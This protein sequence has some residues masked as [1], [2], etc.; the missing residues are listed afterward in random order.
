M[1]QHVTQIAA[2]ALRSTYHG[3]AQWADPKYPGGPRWCSHSTERAANGRVMGLEPFS[4]CD[5]WG[6]LASDNKLAMLTLRSCHCCIRVPRM[7]HNEFLDSSARAR[8]EDDA[9]NHGVFGEVLPVLTAK[10]GRSGDRCVGKLPAFQSST[11]SCNTASGHGLLRYARHCGETHATFNAPSHERCPR[12]VAHW[13]TLRDVM[14][15]VARLQG[16]L[17]AGDTPRWASGVCSCLGNGSQTMR[18]LY[19]NKGIWTWIDLGDI[20]GVEAHLSLG[21]TT[22]GRHSPLKRT[23]GASFALFFWVVSGK[24]ILTEGKRTNCRGSP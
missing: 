20:G 1:A 13:R 22:P 6:M 21:S 17:G 19:L 4:V 18:N 12:R 7:S 16:L 9:S 2:A 3:L 23:G 8:E 24:V 5:T 15:F 14:Q 10:G 11:P